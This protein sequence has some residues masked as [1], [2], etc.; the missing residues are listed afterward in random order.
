MIRRTVLAL[1]FVSVLLAACAVGSPTA[2][3]SPQPTAEPSASP[4]P[5]STPEPSEV[6]WHSFYGGARHASWELAARDEFRQTFSPFIVNLSSNNLYGAPVP[7][8]TVAEQLAGEEPPDFVSGFIGG[9]FLRAQARAGKLRDLTAIWQDLGLEQHYPAAV[10]E[11][12]TVD[13][14][15]HFVPQAIQW[16]PIWYRSDVFAEQGLEP[17]ETWDEVLA[18]C[19]SLSAQDIVPF[20]VSA[21]NWTPPLARW[22]SILNLRLNGVEFH[23]QLLAG[24]VPF[25]DPRVRAVFETWL[26]LFEGGCFEA[27]GVSVN[28]RQAISRFSDGSAA[29]YNLGE[30]IYESTSPSVEE[31]MDFYRLPPIDPD[32]PNAEIASVY[33]Y[34]LPAGSANPEGGEALLRYMASVERQTAVVEDVDRLV[35]DR[36]VDPAVIPAYQ[37]KGMQFVEQSGALVTL[38]EFNAF[39]EELAESGLDAFEFFYNERSQEAI[40][41]VLADLEA[42]R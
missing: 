39:S 4:E 2:A 31:N 10:T 42:A 41:Q 16:N 36:R 19:A 33:G 12:A 40:D 7:I 11:L 34:Y 21:R 29:M 37:Q 1:T 26:E 9:E 32:V 38:F 13:G 27:A 23:R 30:W 5:T 24:E 17:P 15:R 25:T 6:N 20:T 28:Y 3:P 22:F 35:A 8:D 14:R 18:L